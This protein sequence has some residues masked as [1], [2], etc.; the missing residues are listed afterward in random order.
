MP[1]RFTAAL[2][3]LASAAFAA[4]EIDIQVRRFTEAWALI[5]RES[6]EPVTSEKAFYE[7]AI[8]GLLRR[9]DPHSVF[10]DPGQFDQLKQMQTSTR[11][12]FGCVVSVLPGRVIIL[13]TLPG[14]PSAR[15]GLAP[16]D[17][18][19]G[20]NGYSVNRLD[21]DQLV[22]LLGQSRQQPAQLDVRRPGNAR[23]LNF[24]LTPEEM[25]SPSVERAFLLK[26]GIG[27]LRVASFDEKTG[28]EVKQAIEKLGG[29]SLKGLV[30]DLRNNPGGVVL[31]ALEMAALF[32]KPGLRVL[33]VR[34][35]SVK[36]KEESVPA[37][38]QPYEFPVSV[39]INGKS[40]SC[41][42][43]VA[44]A[45]QD[46][47]RAAIVGEPSFGK[48]LV[49]SV[50][51]LS[52]N[53]GLALTTALYYTPSGRSIQKPLDSAQFA[54]AGATSGTSQ[55]LEF[56][57]SGGRTVTGGGGILPDRVVFPQPPTRLRVVL[58]ASGSF[59]SFATA[60]AQTHPAPGDDFAITSGV[61]D[62]FQVYLS[63]RN[64]R[65]GVADWS[66]ERD[67]ISNRLKAEIFNQTLG[68]EKGDEVE[69]QRDVQVLQAI[70]ALAEPVAGSS[71]P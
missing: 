29:R 45:L 17:E 4:E 66:T 9:L 20:I 69:A 15:S 35:R 70:A 57:T 63:Q 24:V 47:D 42:E 21:I 26:P 39:L 5:E 10:F 34:G 18:I 7:G 61:L 50:F 62:E 27:Y 31:A 36:E 65:P 53:A 3:A 8:P 52:D 44:G 23:V 71:R 48:G 19:L 32:L 1:G 49:E 54:L 38:N 68:V 51:P 25:Q 58:D 16:G 64:I 2:F 6:A 55:R 11:K 59:T 43:I 41:S 30:L 46:H 67:F 56:K 60:Y 14:T 22:A 37:N 13:Q 33:T 28:A 40:A 12:G